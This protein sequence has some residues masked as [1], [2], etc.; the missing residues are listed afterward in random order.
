MTRFHRSYLGLGA[1]G[2]LALLTACASDPPPDD[3]LASAEVAYQQAEAAGAAA[4][5]PTEMMSAR[6]K[7]DEAKLAA[8]D[9]KYSRAR[10]LAEEA[11]A[12]SQ[13]AVAKSRAATAEANTNSMRDTL[14]ALREDATPVIPP[15]AATGRQGG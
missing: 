8:A 10:R 5:S 14:D 7:L 2:A 11:Q 6:A 9:E 13:L 3:A 12:D 15:G 4:H 1:F